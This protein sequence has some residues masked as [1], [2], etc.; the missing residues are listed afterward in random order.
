MRDFTTEATT[1]FEGRWLDERCNK[2]VKRIDLDSIKIGRTPPPF[3]LPEEMAEYRALNRSSRFNWDFLP[4]WLME[5]L[6]IGGGTLGMALAAA[7]AIFFNVDPPSQKVQLTVVAIGFFLGVAISYFIGY[8]LDL[9]RSRRSYL[10]CLKY[11][12]RNTT[13]GNCVCIG[14]EKWYPRPSPSKNQLKML[15]RHFMCYACEMEVWKKLGGRNDTSS[16]QGGGN[17]FTLKSAQSQWYGHGNSDLDWRDR[18]MGQAL[19]Y[20]DGD[21]YKANW[22]G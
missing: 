21:S 9:R 19:G 12:E 10:S 22:P 16:S 4:K 1:F 2:A 14:Y 15:P 13:L 18:E 20:E 17:S 6:I 3:L 7:P 11:E 5:L 8:K